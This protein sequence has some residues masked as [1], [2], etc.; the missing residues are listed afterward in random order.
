M[1]MSCAVE[2]APWCDSSFTVKNSNFTVC[3]VLQCLQT[4]PLPVSRFVLMI[5]VLQTGSMH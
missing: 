1:L 2:Q 3:T 5:R 4:P